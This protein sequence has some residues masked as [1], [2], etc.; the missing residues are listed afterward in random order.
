MITF[1]HDNWVNSIDWVILGTITVD[2]VINLTDTHV[3]ACVCVF[4]HAPHAHVYVC[5]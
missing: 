5:V 3:R 1:M 4:V 2:L